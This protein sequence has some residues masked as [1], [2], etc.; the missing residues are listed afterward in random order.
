MRKDRLFTPEPPAAPRGKSG[1]LASAA[2]LLWGDEYVTALARHVGRNRRTVYRWFQDE[3]PIP[4]DVWER[5]LVTL[6]DR[7]DDIN[8]LT[9]RLGVV[10]SRELDMR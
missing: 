5:V 3:S 4:V 8:R 9:P 7:R 10:I 6:D 1:L 2:K